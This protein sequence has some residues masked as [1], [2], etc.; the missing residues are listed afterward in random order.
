M[1]GIG[2]LK[3][4]QVAVGGMRCVDLKNDILKIGKKKK[5]RKKTFTQL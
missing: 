4:V 5:K 2:F 1:T 3:G